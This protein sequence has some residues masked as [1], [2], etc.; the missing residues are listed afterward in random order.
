MSYPYDLDLKFDNERA[1]SDSF[2]PAILSMSINTDDL[3][4]GTKAVGFYPAEKPTLFLE[5]AT[6]GV[7]G[8]VDVYIGRVPDDG[9]VTIGVYDTKGIMILSGGFGDSIPEIINADNFNNVVDVFTGK[10]ISEWVIFSGTLDSS[11]LPQGY[12][13]IRIQVTGGTDPE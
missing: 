9:G 1:T 11:L 10:K 13:N 3:S 7:Q 6:V 8:N 5:A 4:N 12:D 2:S